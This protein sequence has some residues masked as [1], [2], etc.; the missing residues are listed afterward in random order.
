MNNKIKLFALTI[1]V[2]GTPILLWSIIP[3]TKNQWG[4]FTSDFIF[5]Y[6]FYGK[7]SYSAIG[8][9][10]DIFIIYCFYILFKKE[11]N[12]ENNRTYL[13][14]QGISKL[15]NWVFL[16]GLIKES[17]ITKEEKI[18]LLFYLVKLYFTPLMLGFLI[19]NITSVF[20][21]IP[22]INSYYASGNWPGFSNTFLT[23]IFPALFYLILLVDTAIFVFGYLFES[24]NLKNI[25]KSVE[26]TALGWLVAML[27]YPPLNNITAD[28]LGWYS[29]DFSNF[30]NENLSLIASFISIILF[31][32]Y[33]WASVALG[34]KASNLT[35]RGIVS[36]GPYKYVRHPA[37]ISKNL[38]WWIMGIPF[39]IN[40]GFL[41]VFSLSAWTF[42][43]FLRALTEERHLSQDPDYIA[44]MNKVKY[45]FIPGIY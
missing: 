38:S 3:F 33:G 23:V 5:N 24:K 4:S 45:K 27:C 20:Q 37:Y 12:I 34:F 14:C 25:V 1:L 11:G 36:K 2:Y 42:I 41:A 7:I 16:K 17:Q 13:I 31:L 43:Y 8:I 30:G 35:N 26:P 18:S 28:I 32:I 15:W 10:F 21:F 40:V 22:T 19:G 29:S 44:Y 9:I 6:L 39:I